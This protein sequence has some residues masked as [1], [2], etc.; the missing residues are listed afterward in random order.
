MRVGITGVPGAGKS[1]FIEALGVDLC[2]EGH[3]ISVVGLDE[4]PVLG[5]AECNHL[6]AAARGGGPDQPADEAADQGV[7]G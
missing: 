4:R 2:R 3:K 1:T 6:P 7:C 5:G